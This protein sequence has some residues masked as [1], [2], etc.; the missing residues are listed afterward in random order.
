[1]HR[2]IQLSL[3]SRNKFLRGIH[4]A[5]QTKTKVAFLK[6][7]VRKFVKFHPIDLRPEG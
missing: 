4:K 2:N 6:L 3:L 5:T 1:M 7:K